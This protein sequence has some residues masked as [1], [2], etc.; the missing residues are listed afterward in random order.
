MRS[1]CSKIML[2]HSGLGKMYM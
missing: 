2:L 1:P